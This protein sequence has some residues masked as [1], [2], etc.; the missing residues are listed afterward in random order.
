MLESRAIKENNTKL[1]FDLNYRAQRIKFNKSLPTTK[2]KGQI[3]FLSDSLTESFVADLSRRYSDGIAGNLSP[4]F[5]KLK[6]VNQ[7]ISSDTTRGIL[8]RIKDVTDLEPDKVFIMAGINDMSMGRS[9][10]TIVKNYKEIIVNIK[11]KSPQTE[12]F[13]ESVLPVNE[14]RTPIK[15]KNIIALNQKLRLL[16]TQYDAIYIDLY[17]LMVDGKGQLNAS[18]TWDGIHIYMRGFDLWRNEVEKFVN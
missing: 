5:Q 3:V 11:E 10:A 1:A 16:A 17:S 4:L 2:L 8:N 13:I 6:I 12:I 18:W 7:G 14:E 9:V 15:N